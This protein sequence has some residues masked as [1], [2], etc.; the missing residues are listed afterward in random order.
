MSAGTSTNATAG[1]PPPLLV[2]PDG[3][4]TRLDQANSPLLGVDAVHQGA[5]TVPF[6]IGSTL[7]LYTDG[8]VERRDQPFTDGIDQACAVLAT[9]PRDASPDECID[10]LLVALT[11]ERVNAD[12]IAVVVVKRTATSTIRAG[13]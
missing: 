1:H 13:G 7:V 2:G 8:F 10:S 5:A 4:V 3:V 11:D 9:Q 6:P 12:D